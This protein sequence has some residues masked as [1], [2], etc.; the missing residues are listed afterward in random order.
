MPRRIH[1]SDEQIL[2][3]SLSTPEV[4]H[5][6]VRRHGDRLHD[7]MA[8]RT[9]AAVA[10]DLSCDLWETAFVRRRHY[11]GREGTV[12]GWLYG[13]ARLLVAE[14]MRRRDRTARIGPRATEL[15]KALVASEVE[16]EVI[17]KVDSQRMLGSVLGAMTRIDPADREILELW[18]WDRLSY[19]EIG[20]VLAIPGG[21]VRSRISRARSRLAAEAG[22]RWTS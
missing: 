1:R 17:A 12:L 11:D 6:L 5:L 19:A 16:D 3:S 8:R 21:T 10:D 14:E 7:Y 22:M 15:S 20:Q 2:T 18:A 13:I 9:S 4:F